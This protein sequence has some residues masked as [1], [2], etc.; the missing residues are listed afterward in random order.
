M[1][2]DFEFLL[3][4]LTLLTGVVWGWDKLR[5]HRLKRAGEPVPSEQQPP[6]WIDLPRSLFPVIL[7]V[8][9]VR[10]FI[11]EPFRI[12]SGSMIPTLYNG[13]FI[14]V[15]KFSYGLRFPVWH[16]ELVDFGEPARG[17]VI[18]FR[19]PED[20]SQDY[21]KRVVAVPGDHLVYRD[22]Q[23]IINGQALPQRLLGPYYGPE[24]EPGAQLRL[25]RQGGESREILIHNGSRRGVLELTVPEGAY[26]VMGDNRDR[27][28]DSRYWGF[29]PEEN[30][31]GKAFF[32]WLSWNPESNGINWDRLGNAIE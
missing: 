21:I 12:P 22:K 23:L 10:S 5:V 17:D 30:I 26:F 6:W 25:E 14:L 1:H 9:V 24:A 27:S 16:K 3:L 15:N 7:A 11:V 31:V 13:D 32:I 18:V 2:F 4:A 8:L 29:V 19:Y 28:S 20:P